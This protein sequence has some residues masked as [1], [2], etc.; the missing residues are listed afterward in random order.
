MSAS[1]NFKYMHS[2]CGLARWSLGGRAIQ[3]IRLDPIDQL[4]TQSAQVGAPGTLN[5]A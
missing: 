5:A 2:R 1:R 4:F 3:P